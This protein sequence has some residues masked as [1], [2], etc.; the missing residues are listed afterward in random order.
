MAKQTIQTAAATMHGEGIRHDAHHMKLKSGFK[1]ATGETLDKQD[2]DGLR[3]ALLKLES[4]QTTATEQPALDPA[5]A[6]KRAKAEVKERAAAGQEGWDRV[7]EVIE[8]GKDGAPAR[9]QVRCSDPQVTRDG[10]SVCVK[11]R[12][13][14]AQD[15]FQVTRCLPCQRRAQQVLRNK[16]AQRRRQ[17]SQAKPSRQSRRNRKATK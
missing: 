12:E 17:A 2:Q 13:V 10:D 16:L 5:E 15:V 7:V 14:A 6:M 8:A 4:A 9:V 11:T 3:D 1:A